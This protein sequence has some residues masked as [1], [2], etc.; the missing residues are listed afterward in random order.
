MTRGDGFS[1]NGAAEGS[2]ELLLRIKGEFLEMPCLRLTPEQARRLWGLDQAACQALLDSLVD[3]R[4]LKRT[5]EGAY[6]REQ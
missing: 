6:Q 1:T 4:F 2:E 3:A 5:V